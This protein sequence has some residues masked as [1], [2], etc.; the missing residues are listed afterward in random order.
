M[1]LALVLAISILALCSITAQDIYGEYKEEQ[2]SRELN[3]FKN[4][5]ELIS[6]FRNESNPLAHE[7]LDTFLTK[8]QFPDYTR[9]LQGHPRKPVIVI[10]GNHKSSRDVVVMGLSQLMNAR[11]VNHPA[12]CIHKY[13]KLLP[14]GSNLRR[15]YYL[16]SN[17]AGSRYAKSQLNRPIVINGYWSEQLAFTLTH[18]Y[19]P[20]E[21][22]PIH[23][24]IF[25]FPDDLLKPDIIFY[26]DFP[27]K[28]IYHHVTTKSP[29]TWKPRMLEVYT[30]MQARYPIVLKEMK[31]LF[32]LTTEEIHRHI[33]QHLY[34]K[35]F[36]VRNT[37]GT[38]H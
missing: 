18:V 16:L 13:H 29:L 10:E 20:G 36:G 25:A 33:H 31:P 34:D 9:R 21:L 5:D 2:A 4:L 37:T 12:P 24:D 15:A 3:I 38:V 11:Y 28:M 1:S 27:N 6:F 32:K 26:L 35:V 22:P 30:H 23:S 8:C 7:V 19:P 17:Y 14:K